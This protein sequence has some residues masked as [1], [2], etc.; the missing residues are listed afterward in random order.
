MTGYG[1]EISRKRVLLELE[2]RVRGA[3]QLDLQIPSA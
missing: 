2:A 3:G 1:G